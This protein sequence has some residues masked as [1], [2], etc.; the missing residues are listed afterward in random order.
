MADSEDNAVVLCFNSL[1]EMIGNRIFTKKENYEKKEKENIEVN[2]I[3][4][5]LP[6]E[7]ILLICKFLSPGEIIKF[8]MTC[9]IAHFITNETYL[10]RIKSMEYH[11]YFIWKKIQIITHFNEKTIIGFQYDIQSEIKK[12]TAKKN[13]PNHNKFYLQDNEEKIK[14]KHRKS[15]P[16]FLNGKIGKF[17]SS[18]KQRIKY[19]QLLKDPQSELLGRAQK[20]F[21]KLKELKEMK[22]VQEIIDTRKRIADS[23]KNLLIKYLTI[24]AG[25]VPSAFL[26]TLI[27]FNFTLSYEINHKAK[28]AISPLVI[29]GLGFV[30][31]LG[32]HIF[33]QS[34]DTTFFLLFLIAFSW[35]FGFISFSLKHDEI[36]DMRW[37]AIFLPIWVTLA[38]I[39]WIVY[40]DPYLSILTRFEQIFYFGFCVSFASSF[41]LLSLRL[42]WGLLIPYFYIFAPIILLFLITLVRITAP[43][44]IR[45]RTTTSPDIVLVGIFMCL[46]SVVVL[47]FRLHNFFHNFTLAFLPF[48]LILLPVSF[49]FCF[50]LLHFSAVEM[51]EDDDYD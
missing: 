10:W 47:V 18:K 15:P 48:Y 4:T 41:F 34:F 16:I 31:I 32:K 12:I 7:I 46:L 37:I 23:K 19:I 44:T 26:I 17:F 25:L 2:L 3:F 38:I 42:D 29:L 6:S 14:N 49:L 13:T 24:F 22:R 43:Q 39:F 28:F 1:Q 30:V 35:V 50:F 9:K 5:K 21:L 11:T 33:F 45:L 27:I 51:S 20:L 36:V 8:G 40:K